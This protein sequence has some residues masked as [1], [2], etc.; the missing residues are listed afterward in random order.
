MAT[1]TI[2]RRTFLVSLGAGTISVALGGNAAQLNAAEY[3]Q[4]PG[5]GARINAWV[6]LADDGSVTIISPSAEMG[7]GV[8]T[9]SPLLVAEDMDADWAKIRVLQAPA[10]MAYGNP[11]FGGVQVTG[12][13]A[14]TPGYYDILRLAGAQ[15][16]LVLIAMAADILGV[17]RATL[18]TDVHRVVHDATGQSL[19]YG[20]IVQR[21]QMPDPIPEATVAHLKPATDFRYIGRH[22][23]PRIDVPSKVDGTAVY[24]IDIDLPRMLHGIVLRSTVQ[25]ETPISVD[26]SSAKAVPGLRHVVTLPYGVGLIGDTVQAVRAARDLLTVE[27][28]TTSPARAYNSAEMLASYQGIV[29]DLSRSGGVAL[30][31]GGAL[32]A[33]AAAQAVLSA[34]YLADHVYH[35]T[36]EP[37]TATAQVE[38]D[39]ATIW[40]PTQAQSLT[41]WVASGILQIPPENVTL[42]TTLLGGGLGRKAEADFISDAVNLASAVPGQP[43]KVV[44]TREDDLRHGKFRPLVATHARLMLGETGQIAAWHQRL[45]ADSI[46]ARWY[47]DGFAESGGMDDVVYGGL[48]NGYVLPAH[49]TEY[50]RQDS[51]VDVSFFRGTAEGYTKFSVE[52]LMD[53]AAQ[54]AGK[55]PL[56]Y[57]LEHLSQDPRGQANLLAVAEMAGWNE[58]R[59]DGRALG[60][61]YS[62]AWGARCSQVAEVSLDRETGIIT[63]H[64]LWCAVDPGLAIQPVNIEAQM[65]SAMLMGASVALHEQINIVNGEVQESNLDGYRVLRMS[66]AP[67]ITVK[68]IPTDSPPA[69]IGEIGVPPVAP[70]IANAVARL[71]G[72]V[73]LRHL[74]FLPERVIAALAG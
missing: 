52:C 6:S 53:E 70:A 66:E 23:I 22:D 46:Y 74:P 54:Q 10:D 4:T 24:G 3:V 39:R 28:T 26:D 27:W 59:P 2:S 63:V 38:G 72:G 37:M 34:T 51:G 69:G 45:A 55:D 43:V 18:R 16:R 15:T 11:I 25:H 58:L 19:E 57:R 29:E 44:W 40:A 7:Q 68:V 20:Q 47:P 65:M 42:I 36:M 41:T 73:R 61:A 67:K 17:E 62:N 21:G 30:D 12:G 5:E 8:L 50:L 14:T 33:L 60:L 49:R 1:T 48:Q 13:S 56:A 35:A 31:E 9:A 64:Q 71:T 32:E